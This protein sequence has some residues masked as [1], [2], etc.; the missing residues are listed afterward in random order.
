MGTTRCSQ[1]D[2]VAKNIWKFCHTNN[3]WVT[4]A[5]IPGSDNTKADF[6]SRKE[7]KEA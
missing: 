1:C 6:E 7:Y 4:A 5:H 2:N 3:I